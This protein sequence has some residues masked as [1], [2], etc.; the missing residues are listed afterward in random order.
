MGNIAWPI[1]LLSGSYES[2]YQVPNLIIGTITT[3][4]F[5]SGILVTATIG[6][7]R[8]LT[9]M[10]KRNLSIKWCSSIG[11]MIA[12]NIFALAFLASTPQQDDYLSIKA[13]KSLVVFTG[14]NIVDCLF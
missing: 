13:R 7:E 14:V 4:I 5:V 12:L 3:I 11:I 2:S 1:L 10:K 6:N 9:L 8:D